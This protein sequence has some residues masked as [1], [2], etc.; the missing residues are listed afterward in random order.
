MHK[1]IS[2]KMKILKS[3]KIWKHSMRILG[4]N[5]KNRETEH[6]NTV[7][8][9]KMR[10]RVE[11]GPRRHEWKPLTDNA[12]RPSQSVHT[13]NKHRLFRFAKYTTPRT[14]RS[15]HT[16]CV[17]ATPC[18]EKYRDNSIDQRSIRGR[19]GYRHPPNEFFQSVSSQY[20][21]YYWNARRGRD[22]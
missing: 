3:A 16:R 15:P 4:K 13:R 20:H 1:I 2:H 7:G 21:G 8:N 12:L 18:M 14:F 10:S 9:W 5:D 19:K 6:S 11:R 17:T 22:R